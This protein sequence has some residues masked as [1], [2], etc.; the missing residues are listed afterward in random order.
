MGIQNVVWFYL[1]VS[2]GK[3]MVARL[4]MGRI[5]DRLSYIFIGKL[6]DSCSRQVERLGGSAPFISP[7]ASAHVL[8]DPVS[9]CDASLVRI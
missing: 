4:A 3:G 7:L 2:I 6:L 8:F 5:W 1:F 9:C